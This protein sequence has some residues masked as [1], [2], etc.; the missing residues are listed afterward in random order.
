MLGVM[1]AAIF[2][3]TMSSADSSIN[4][5]AAVVTK[6]VYVPISNRV[7]GADPSD[8]SQLIVG[9]ASVAVMGVLAIWIA[10]NM[11]RFGG[12]FD[13]YLRAT[14]L[15]AAP[16]YIP[17]MLG[18]VYTRTPFWSGMASFGGGVV[19]VIAVSVAANLTLGLPADS[20]GALFQDIRI[21][22]LT[23]DMTRYELNTFAGIFAS[24]G[25][26]FASSLWYERSTKY[27]PTLLALVRDLATPAYAD[28][29]EIDVR[30]FRAYRIAG[31]LALGLGF[32][33]VVMAVPAAGAAGARINFAGAAL[34]SAVGGLLI[35]M[36]TRQLKRGDQ[37]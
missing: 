24:A 18:L 34:A 19:A 15:Y 35:W 4:W 17:M 26:F 14:S 13:T 33:L 7:R 21:T 20:F 1:V 22:V 3:A 16:M 10:F 9:R 28:N 32:V 27:R 36:S 11:E 37:P 8:R 2:A 29:E 25:I 6:D 31:I 30:G 12:A 5:M 23:L